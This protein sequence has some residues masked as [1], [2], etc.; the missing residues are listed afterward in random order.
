MTAPGTRS[1][2]PADTYG[3]MLAGAG[4]REI[5]RRDSLAQGAVAVALYESPHYDLVVPG[6][7]MTR[8]SVNLLASPVSGALDGGRLRSFSGARH[9]VF[10]T[11]S[12]AEARW[13]KPRPSRHVNLYFSAPHFEDPMLPNRAWHTPLLDERLPRVGRLAEALARELSAPGP[14]SEM[15]LDALARLLLV[16]VGRRHGAREPAGALS[17]RTLARIDEFVLAHLAERL[18]V[19]DLAAVAGL[20][21][22]HFAHAFTRITGRP[23]HRHV[24][25]LRVKRALQLLTTTQRPLA[26]VAAD[27][28]FA[29][30]QHMTQVLRMHCGI[31]PG[32]LRAGRSL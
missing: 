32:R 18:L 7:A 15:A 30:Q 5:D 11:P 13:R 8:L 2:H 31:T 22:T 14:M 21:P 28:G 20:S 3:R 24:L 6:L 19:R 1:G 27:C 16:E 10:L 26:D 12:Q 9:S 17:P 4:G 29:S 23:P 25:A